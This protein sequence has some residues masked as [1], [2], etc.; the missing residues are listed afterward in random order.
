MS[1]I[2]QYRA[3]DFGMERC[4]LTG[5]IPSLEALTATNQTLNQSGTPVHIN[6]WRLETYERVNAQTLSWSTRPKRGSLFAQWDVS[7]GKSFTSDEFRCPSGSLHT[8]EFTCTGAG[9]HLKFQQIPK[10]KE[11]GK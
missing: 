1:T 11:L 10:Y 3:G 8:F 7:L 2:A 9:C 4:I 6:V 5:A